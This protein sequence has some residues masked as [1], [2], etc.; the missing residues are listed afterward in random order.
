M[1]MIMMFASF[2]VGTAALYWGYSM[3]GLDSVAGWL[4][5]AGAAW[6]LAQWQ[7]LSW[8][9]SLVLLVF[10][11]AAAYGLWVGL[12][13]SLMTVGAV[14]GLLGWD[15]SDFLHRMRFA[16]PTDDKRG[17]EMRHLTRVL[18]VMALGLVIAGISSIVRV[19]IPFELAV[20]LILLAAVGLTRVV[21]W[22]QRKGE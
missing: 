2:V 19:K 11:S 17:M 18:I 14:G 3:G 15:L 13:A 22:L 21:A 12:P 1:S 7:K 6:M 16:S 5:A 10:V 4:V 9:A 20:V 8:V